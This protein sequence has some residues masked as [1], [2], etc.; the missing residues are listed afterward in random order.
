MKDVIGCRRADKACNGPKTL[1]SCTCATSEYVLSGV[2]WRWA[3]DQEM[4]WLGAELACLARK[5]VMRRWAQL[6][7]LALKIHK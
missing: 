6:A 7:R 4:R 3:Y 1:S 2:H 5:S